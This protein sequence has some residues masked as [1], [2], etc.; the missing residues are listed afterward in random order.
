MRPMRRLWKWGMELLP[1]LRG[2]DGKRLVIQ[3]DRLARKL[4]ALAGKYSDKPHGTA[5][6]VRGNDTSVR[7]LVL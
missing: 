4:C 3:N 7:A 1:E 5:V 6:A 2:K